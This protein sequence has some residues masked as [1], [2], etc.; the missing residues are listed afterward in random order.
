MAEPHWDEQAALAQLEASERATSRW[1]LLA[2]LLTVLTAV[3]WAA[4]FE[5]DELTRGQGKVVPA[6]REQVVQS[7][8]GGT[9]SEIRVREGQVVEAGQVLLRLD[10]GRSK[11][12]VQEVRERVWALQAQVARL[13]AEST[14]TEPR[15]EAGV[16]A[17][18][19]QRE[20]ALF[21]SRRAA[22]AASQKAQDD[23]LAALRREVELT[24]PLVRQGLV[25]EVDVLRLKRQQAELDGQRADLRNRFLTE[26]HAELARTAAELAQTQE[27]VAL[28]ADS[29]RHTDVTAPRRGIVKALQVNTVGAVVQGGQSLL[30]LV[31][32]D[33]ELQV[34]AYVSPADVAFIRPGQPALIKLSAYDFGR[35]GGL[36]GTVESLS[37]DTLRNER[38]RLQRPDRTL[39]TEEGLYRLVVRFDPSGFR[40]H[41]QPLQVLPGMTA[42]V[43]VKTGSK[44]VL[45]YV[46]RPVR[47]ISGA[48]HE[49]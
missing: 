21:Q 38:E 24:E 30:T 46:V 48:L 45:A 37:P 15:F 13:R 47:E 25:P 2:T 49:R 10:Q 11:P 26:A 22:L 27:T 18:L 28:R 8:D 33:S 17:A 31:P 16:P 1:L 39:E 4:W 3:G 6:A 42:S 43:E 5:L 9:L 36:S 40:Y 12:Y 29:L 41:G 23:A 19:A 44:T 35:Y 14:G 34:E 32:L 20:L 7:L